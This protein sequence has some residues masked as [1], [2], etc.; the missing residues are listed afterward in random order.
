MVVALLFL[1]LVSSLQAQVNIE[2]YRGKMGIT[3]GARVSLS[4]DLGNVDVVNC[5]GAG[6]ITVNTDKGVFLGVFKGGVG[7]LG[8]ERFA[9][10][11]V[12]HLRWTLT[13]HP[14]YQPEIFAQGDYAKS[15]RLDNRMLAGAGL[16]L[17]AYKAEDST[18]SFGS[19]LMWE[20]ENLDLLPAD[21]HAVSTELVRWS[22]YINLSFDGRI[23]F[24][25]TAYVQTALSDSGDMRL[26]GSAELS[27]PIIGPLHQ[28]TSLD[29]R[30]DS[31]PPLD[32]EKQDFKFGASFGLKF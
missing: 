3:G 32:V 26:L 12:L 2:H 24:A 18:L 21:R 5:D 20:R 4:S 19:A 16:R 22:N 23:D 25:T 6:N 8:G 9:N 14:R 11:G 10:S 29:F 28:T 7:V 13:A 27:T 1:L 31:E 15:R 17:N 30:I